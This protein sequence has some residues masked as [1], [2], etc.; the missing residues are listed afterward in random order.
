MS[1]HV[2]SAARPLHPIG[3]VA[4]RTGLSLDVL[5]VW[6]RRYGVVEPTR[7]EAG[8]RLYSDADIERLRL[9]AQATSAGQSIGQI[10]ALPV[11]GLRELVRGAEAAQW[12]S[13][14]PTGRSEQA[15]GLVEQAL[16][17]TRAMDGG[18]VEYVLRRA[19]SLLG[20]PA[21]LEE[22]VVD[23]SRRIGDEWHAGRLTIAH[24]HLAT[25]VL[26]P[27]LAQLRAELPV[28][29]AAPTLVVATPVGERHEIGALLAAGAAAVEGWR[30]TYLGAD[31]PSAEVARA[32]LDVNARAVALSSVYVADVSSL[33]AELRSLR[34]GLPRDVAIL[35]GG[36]GLGRLEAELRDLHVVPMAGLPE[37]RNF[38]REG[39]FDQGS[40][41]GQK[42]GSERAGQ[43]ERDGVSRREGGSTAVRQ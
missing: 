11:D 3:V 23:L 32:A 7:D 12:T 2:R 25:G 40:A 42:S 13:T 17:R 14:R 41:F 33:A 15:A 19:A 27:L 30:V 38:L 1:H 24:E 8:R 31:L 18:G 20:T 37:L 6:E 5:R 26:R 22:V 9:L 39:A 43:P 34:D 29:P 36:A 28:L 35:V 10:A 21:F 4:E 16:E